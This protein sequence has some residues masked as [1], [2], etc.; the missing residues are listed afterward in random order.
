MGK[1]FQAIVKTLAFIL[2]DI[3]LNRLQWTRVAIILVGDDSGLV[4]CSNVSGE[5]S[6]DSGFLFVNNL[7]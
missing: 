6:V 1:I 5:S 7:F 3:G 2:F 4:H